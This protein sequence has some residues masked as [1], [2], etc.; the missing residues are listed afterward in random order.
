MHSSVIYLLNRAIV[1][2][3]IDGPEAG[4]KAL[5][6][7]GSDPSMDSYH[8]FDA[9]LGELYRRAGDLTRARQ[10]LLAARKKTQAPSDHDLTDRR[11]AQ[12]VQTW[13]AGLRLGRRVCSRAP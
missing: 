4:I 3:E 5:E 11:L 8:L 7:I 6:E 1:V 2:A 9:T 13:L 10:Y 12:C